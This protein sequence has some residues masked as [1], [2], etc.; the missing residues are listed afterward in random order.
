MHNKN[1]VSRKAKMTSN[2]GHRMVHD[3]LV[4]NIFPFPVTRL[5]FNLKRMMFFDFSAWLAP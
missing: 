4:F 2:L 1:L 5:C 3:N